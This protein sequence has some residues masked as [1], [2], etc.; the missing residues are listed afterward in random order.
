MRQVDEAGKVNVCISFQVA[1]Q[2]AT[3]LVYVY[4]F[5]HITYLTYKSMYCNVFFSHLWQ[6]SM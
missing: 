6:P 3:M 5:R 4:L 2:W 1:M